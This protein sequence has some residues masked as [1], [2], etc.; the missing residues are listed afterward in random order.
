MG[1]DNRAVNHPI[2]QI[3]II[4]KMNQH[5]LPYAALTPTPKAFEDT[6][7]FAIFTGQQ[8]PLRAAATDPHDRFH[9]TPALSLVSYIDIRVL[10]QK[11]PNPFPLF[12]G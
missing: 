2:L 3:G 4:R 12:V 6:V 7:P 10:P 9:E 5:P 1:A 11:V 8:T